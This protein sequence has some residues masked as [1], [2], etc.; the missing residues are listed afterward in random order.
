MCRLPGR[1]PPSFA[2]LLN[3]VLFLRSPAA[4]WETA[5]S[6]APTFSSSLTP[7]LHRCF[8]GDRRLAASLVRIM[9]VMGCREP[10]PLCRVGC[11]ALVSYYYERVAQRET[12][13]A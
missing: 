10:L 1:P 8:R 11:S 12:P 6:D 9:H 4:E 7:S 2:C 3:S 5:R 13:R